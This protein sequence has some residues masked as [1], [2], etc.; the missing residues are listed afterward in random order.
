MQIEKKQHSVKNNLFFNT[1]LPNDAQNRYFFN[2][3]IRIKRK[4]QKQLGKI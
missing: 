3:K 1:D 4:N 2:F